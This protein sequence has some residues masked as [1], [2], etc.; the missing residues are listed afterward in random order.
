LSLKGRVVA[1][2]RPIGQ[3]D[4]IA[5]LVS[6]LGGT[7]YIAPTVEIKPTKN[8]TPVREFIKKAIA[9]QIDFIIFTSQNGIVGLVDASQKLKLKAE[10]LA[11]LNSSKI[12]AIGPRTKEKLQ[13]YGIKVDFTPSNFTSKGIAESLNM[14]VSGKIVALPR[15]KKAKDYLRDE[16]KKANATVLEVPVYE[17][18]LPTDKSKVHM[19]VQD[20]VCGKVNI[21]TFTSS[22]TALNLFKIADERHL[23]RRLQ[24][25]LNAG[26]TVAAIGPE[27]QKTLEEIGV[28]VD[29]APDTYTTEA[30]VEALVRDLN[31]D[32]NRSKLRSN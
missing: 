16:L 6:K 29:V 8:L 19:L 31:T 10:L 23:R 2:T 3:T 15:M 26:V 17:S 22:G 1:I 9:G 24:D 4:E 27:T 28:R 18:S 13:S 14:Q 25:C 7:P 21:I 11:A 32:P 20:I 5:S 30:M 12:V